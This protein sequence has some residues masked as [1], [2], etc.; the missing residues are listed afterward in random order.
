MS[1][2]IIRKATYIKDTL[3]ISGGGCYAWIAYQD[4]DK[5]NKGVFKVGMALNFSSRGENYFTSHPLGLYFVCFL[6]NPV[7]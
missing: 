1:S 5:N 2:R 6:Q 4:V 3:K 7:V